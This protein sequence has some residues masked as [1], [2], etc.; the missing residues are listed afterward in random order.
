M[1]LFKEQK[2]LYY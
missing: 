2:Q 1:Y